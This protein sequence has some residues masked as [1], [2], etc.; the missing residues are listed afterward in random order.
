MLVTEL[1]GEQVWEL[2]LHCTYVYSIYH[3]AHWT[4]VAAGVL[5]F[6]SVNCCH[7]NIVDRNTLPRVLSLG[8]HTDPSCIDWSPTIANKASALNYMQV[9]PSEQ[10]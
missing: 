9:L 3:R 5:K 7:V 8:T 10:S 4:G 6:N 2:L 1:K